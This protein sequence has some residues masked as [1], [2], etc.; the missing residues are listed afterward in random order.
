MSVRQYIGARYVPRFSDVNGGVWSNVYSYEPLTIVKNGNDY[1]TSKKSVP[2]G[3]QITNTEYWTKTGDYNGAISGLDTRVTALENNM[4]DKSRARKAIYLGNSYAIGYGTEAN[5]GLY[6]RT[7][8]L[9]DDS[10]LYYDGGV[11][12]LQYTGHTV[13][14]ETLLTRA[15]NDADGIPADEVTDL[16][17]LSAWGDSQALKAGGSSSYANFT[18][19]MNSLVALAKGHYPNLSNIRLAYVEIRSRKTIPNTAE[20]TSYYNEPFETHSILKILSER[21]DISYIGWLGW[22]A[23]MM[24]DSFCAADHYHP[25]ASGNTV[26]ASAIRAALSGSYQ[27][28]VRPIISSAACNAIPSGGLGYTANV[29][30]DDVSIDFGLVSMSA[31]NTATQ[32]TSVTFADFTRANDT[33]FVVPAT[34]HSASNRDLGLKKIIVTPP[35]SMI[36]LSCQAK[37][38]TEG[39]LRIDGLTFDNPVSTTSRSNGGVINSHVV[40]INSP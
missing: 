9:F 38:T 33:A 26:I 16:V 40:I 28:M 17:I 29:T 15:I 39:V 20:G 31:G 18:S 23:F 8:D 27:Y 35:D 32:Y 2:V 6:A 30:P 7:K 14:F 36:T 3:I 10:R 24:G 34:L 4:S 11:G 22:D 13:T 19:A 5:N 1:Y 25:S 37:K 12:F 21:S